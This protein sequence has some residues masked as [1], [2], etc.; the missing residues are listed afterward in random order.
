M[1]YCVM[2]TTMK[3][4]KNL[5][6]DE[7]YSKLSGKFMVQLSSSLLSRLWTDYGTK[8][9]FF[10]LFKRFRQHIDQ[11]THDDVVE[12]ESGYDDET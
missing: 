4:R 5:F 3:K 12:A 7:A 11:Q 8:P 1:N 2:S 6:N 10:Y 9:G